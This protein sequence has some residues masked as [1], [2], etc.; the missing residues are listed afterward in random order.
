VT[1]K[2]LAVIA[3]VVAGGLAITLVEAVAHRFVPLGP[4]DPRSHVPLNPPTVPLMLTVIA[5]WAVGAFVAGWV[6]TKIARA[7]YGPAAASGLV[8]AGA[9]LTMV[10][11]IPSPV[12]FWIVGLGQFVPMALLGFRAVRPLT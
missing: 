8:L 6:A 7:G 1:R 4:V 12:W 10:I 11:A 2:V 5:G 9:G 3:A